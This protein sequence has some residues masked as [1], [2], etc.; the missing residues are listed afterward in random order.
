MKPKNIILMTS[1]IVMVA[2]AITFVALCR[3]QPEWPE[4]WLHIHRGQS[5]AEILALIPKLDTSLK[6]MKGDQ[7]ERVFQS[8]TFG[9]VYQYLL[10]F[11]GEDDYVD[12]IIVR[13][14]TEHFRLFR[15]MANRKY[16]L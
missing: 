10:V 7:S 11:Y 4:A 13:T 3:Y 15:N 1:L 14:E 2:A 16:N 9:R 6:E 5:R 8:P 12:Y